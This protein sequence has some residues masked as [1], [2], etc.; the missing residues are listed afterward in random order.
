MAEA[1]VENPTPSNTPKYFC[2]KCSV[3]VDLSPELPGLTCPRCESG[4]IEE[5]TQEL[6]EQH[7]ART[8][9]SAQPSTFFSGAEMPDFLSS[10]L[11]P[12]PSAEEHDADDDDDEDDSDD[13]N[14]YFGVARLPSRY[15]SGH[16][17]GFLHRHRFRG[18]HHSPRSPSFESSR[19]VFPRFL[20]DVLRELTAGSSG[21][22]PGLLPLLPPL[23]H[24]DPRDYAWG[25]DGLD[26]AITQLLNQWDCPGSPPASADDIDRL[27]TLN[28]AQEHIDKESQCSVCMEDFALDE[29]VLSLVCQHLFHKDCIKPWLELH[30]TCPICRQPVGDG[31]PPPEAPRAGAGATEALS[32][33]AVAGSGAS[34]LPPLTDSWSDCSDDTTSSEDN[35]P[36]YHRRAGFGTTGTGCRSRFEMNHEPSAGAA[37]AGV[38]DISDGEEKKDEDKPAPA[39][40]EDDARAAETYVTAATAGRFDCRRR[41]KTTRRQLSDLPNGVSSSSSSSSEDDYDTA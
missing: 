10:L 9:R 31:V 17:R 35:E 6:E 38:D 2:H 5:I 15:G 27:Q 40:G 19:T 18:G 33:A 29:S 36:T 39:D 28:I 8:E 11:F 26:N 32:A 41:L 30:N 1:A 4:F 24:G 22:M 23:F 37:A 16:T 13:E 3:S 7:V 21:R 20:E 14:G 25:A 34:L 12:T